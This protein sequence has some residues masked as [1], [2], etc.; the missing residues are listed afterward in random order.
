VSI[1]AR[2]RLGAAAAAAATAAVLVSAL[3]GCDS[4]PPAP[5]TPTRLPIPAVTLLPGEHPLAARTV[6]D[7]NLAFTP[8]GLTCD[9]P[10]V[11]GTHGE[12]NA[13]GQYCRVT[14]EVY[15]RDVSFHTVSVGRQQLVDRTGRRYLPAYDPMNIKRQPGSLS[16]GSQ[17]RILLQVWFELP[18]S[19]HAARI[20]L[21][22]DHEPSGLPINA[23]APAAPNGRCIPLR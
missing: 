17:D 6:N 19:A 4:S 7:G 11:I 8:L 22:G 16:L 3:G 23:P 10:S 9:I 14:L 2:T 21:H 5:A 13:R 18:E 20:C 12:L 15:N 1:V